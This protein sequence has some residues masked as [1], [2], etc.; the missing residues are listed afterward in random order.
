MIGRRMQ[1]EN[2]VK[3]PLKFRNKFKLFRKSSNSVR[4]LQGRHLDKLALGAFLSVIF[5]VFMFQTSK[6]RRYKKLYLKPTFKFTIEEPSAIGYFVHWRLTLNK[7][8]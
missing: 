4:I 2:A 5:S 6:E 3:L 1:H 7:C 8:T